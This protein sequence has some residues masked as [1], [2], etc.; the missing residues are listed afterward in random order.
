MPAVQYFGLK[1]QPDMYSFQHD[2]LNL[3]C[4]VYV[5]FSGDKK[6]VQGPTVY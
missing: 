2:A 6:R 4:A 3:T 5:F 1:I